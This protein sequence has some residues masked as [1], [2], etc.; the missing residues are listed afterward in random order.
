VR[1]VSKR[2]RFDTSKTLETIVKNVRKMIKL[3]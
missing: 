1:H 2:F 3:A